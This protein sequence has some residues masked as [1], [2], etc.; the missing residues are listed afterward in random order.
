M[1][2]AKAYVKASGTDTEGRLLME[3][4]TRVE[5]DGD[6]VHLTS[7]LGDSEE[8]HAC[9]SSVSFLDSTLVLE[10]AK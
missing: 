8:L 4:V 1:C 5:V 6:R 2:L 3:N 7:L 9:I 10:T